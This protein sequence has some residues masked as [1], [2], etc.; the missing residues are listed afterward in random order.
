VRAL[1]EHSVLGFVTALG[2]V[3]L[4]SFPY[5][6]S[7]SQGIHRQPI[8]LIIYCCLVIGA[9]YFVLW[10]S[11]ETPERRISALF[12]VMPA[13]LMMMVELFYLIDRMNT[14][15]KGYMAVW[16]LSG[17]STMLLLFFVG[18]MVWEMGGKRLRYAFTTIIAVFVF[19][20]V[21]GA[22][23]NVYATVTLKR[24]PVRFYTLDGTA[25]LPEMPQARED[26]QV[27][28][29][30][31]AARA[32]GADLVIPFM[33]WGWERE[34]EPTTRQRSLAHLMIDAGADVVVGAHP[35]ITQGAE[36]YRGKLIVYSLGNFVFDSFTTDATRTGWLLRLGLNRQGMTQWDTRIAF[37][38]EEGIPQPR[39]G[40]SSPCGKAGDSRVQQC[41]NP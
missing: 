7:L 4:A 26:A 17:V 20:Q 25:F 39:P 18:R 16:M 5:L 24:V 19:V 9:A 10:S 23:F 13:F 14:I 3:V 38:D 12:I 33:H 41:A 36:Y 15:F 21:L 29:D 35:H 30:I 6:A 40:A 11:R 8:G 22:A 28:A 31:R 37:M 2:V 34:P 32:A 1:K 27:V